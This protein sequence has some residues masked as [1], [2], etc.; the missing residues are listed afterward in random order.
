MLPQFQELRILMEAMD[1]DFIACFDANNCGNLM[2]FFW[3]LLV[4]FKRNCADYPQILRLWEVL[5]TVGPF[6]GETQ[7]SAANN[8]HLL[9]AL[10]M[11]EIQQ[12]VV[13][14]SSLQ[15]EIVEVQNH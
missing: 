6:H 13:I 7:S 8:F 12:E 11:L 9:V 5:W 15:A 10:S 14:E 1:P 2:F 3:W 4:L